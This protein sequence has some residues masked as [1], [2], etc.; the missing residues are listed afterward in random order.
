MNRY[1]HIN[2]AWPETIPA[3]TALE[4]ERAAQRIARHFKFRPGRA[5]KVWVAINA[6]TNRLNRGWRRLVHDL[7][8]RWFRQVYRAKRPH[9]PL[10]ERY[11][12]QVR[13][14]VLA[15]GWLDG[16]LRPKVKAKPAVDLKA[17][18]AKRVAERM[19]AWEVKKKRAET[20]LKKLRR[21]ARYYEVTLSQ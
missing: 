9:D 20:A 17:Q 12:D 16:K 1:D 6:P 15:A 11:E 3:I 4:A 5:R 8:H 2:T 13:E 7:S 21:Q 10:H 14:Y 18:R 19:K